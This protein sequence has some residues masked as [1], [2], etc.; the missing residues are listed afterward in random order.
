[1]SKV[2]KDKFVLEKQKN[3]SIVY[4]VMF[5]YCKV[6]CAPRS[7]IDAFLQ[8][9]MI[10]YHNPDAEISKRQDHSL[11]IEKNGDLIGQTV[12]HRNFNYMMSRDHTVQAYD[13]T[14]I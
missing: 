9:V 13:V 7:E 5:E 14:L 11:K 6:N 4:E 2:P 1:M 10:Y 3:E 8:S 12:F